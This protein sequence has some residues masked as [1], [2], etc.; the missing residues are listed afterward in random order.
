MHLYV[1]RGGRVVEPRFH[2]P[3][4]TGFVYFKLTFRAELRRKLVVWV[5]NRFAIFP[6]RFPWLI[7]QEGHLGESVSRKL[8]GSLYLQINGVNARSLP[9]LWQYPAIKFA[10]FF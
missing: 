8:V 1:Q 7:I 10:W 9:N 4:T 3:V 2:T 6:A 5:I